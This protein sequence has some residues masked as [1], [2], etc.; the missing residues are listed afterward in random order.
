[1]KTLTQIWHE[2]DGVLTFEWVLLVTILTIGIVGGLAAA[3]DGIIEELGDVT[4]S[5]IA[6]DQGY[7]V[8][9]PPDITI[10]SYPAAQGSSDSQFIDN[11]SNIVDDQRSNL[12]GQDPE[13][14]DPS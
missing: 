14:D 13:S 11:L 12:T 10:H 1:M 5:A 8:D 3:R 2:D 4:E 9:L 7:R 6:L